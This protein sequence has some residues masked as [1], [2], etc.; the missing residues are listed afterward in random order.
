MA[1]Q[2]N[3]LQ[4]QTRAALRLPGLNMMAFGAGDLLDLHGQQ[5]GVIRNTGQVLFGRIFH[6]IVAVA[7]F[8]GQQ[9]FDFI[10]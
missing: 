1:H 4:V 8:I 5:R 9:A 10:R 6:E 7:Q 2:S 3:L